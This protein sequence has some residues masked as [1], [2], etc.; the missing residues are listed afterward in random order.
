MRS[1]STFATLPFPPR[2]T[3]E[4]PDGSRLRALSRV[5]AGSMAH[6]EL[7][8]G[9]TSR[10]V[11]HRTVEEIWFVL[12]GRGEIWRKAGRV[13]QIVVLEPGTSLTIPRGTHFQFRASPEAP[14]EF[15]GVTMPPWPGNQEAEPVVG[16]WTPTATDEW[17]KL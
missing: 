10:A 5:D 4:A 9:A 13:E 14:L 15:V 17:R 11:T 7:A 6:F 3:E 1:V 16:P 2:P 12:R 8:A